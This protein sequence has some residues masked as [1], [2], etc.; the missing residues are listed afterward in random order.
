MTV[1]AVAYG[2]DYGLEFYGGMCS[3]VWQGK[4]RLALASGQTNW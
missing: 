1:K 4:P 3:D 2:E